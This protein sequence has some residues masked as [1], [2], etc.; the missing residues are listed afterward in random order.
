MLFKTR[1]RDVKLGVKFNSLLILA[2]I[3]GMALSGAALSSVLQQRA[4]FEVSS[5]AGLLMETISSLRSYTQDRVNP[6][7]QQKLATEPE[8]IPEA[9]PTF[10]IREV[11]ETFRQNKKYQ[12][13]FYKDATLNPTN[14]R[15]KADGFETD[16]INRF[17]SE[18]QTKE[19]SG[20]RKLAGSELFY[21]ARPLQITDQSCLQCHSTIAA[22]PKSLLTT[23]GPENGFGWKLNDV[24]GAQI[25]SVPAEDVFD[26]AHQSFTRIM[27]VLAGIFLAVIL[28]INLLLRKVVVRRISHIARTAQAIS[29][30]ETSADFEENS[31]D[32][33]GT[34]AMAFNRMKSSLSIALNM[35][36]Q[37][38]N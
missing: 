37:Q 12:N 17:R 13:F 36:N 33:I 2:F 16:L 14:L 28:L 19:L 10:S 1:F 6:L 23:Y 18:S 7:L 11:F 20:F 3:I 31:R 34:L 38:G 27:T 29:T 26:D 9:I 24:I 22:A 15:D 30:G 21:I 35:L 25:I 32:E 8:F 4:Q 5:Q